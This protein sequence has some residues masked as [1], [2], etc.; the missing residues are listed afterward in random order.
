[1]DSLKDIDSLLLLL[2]P[3][4]AS[5]VLLLA[6]VAFIFRKPIR[7]HVYLIVLLLTIPLCAVLNK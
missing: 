6:C 3:P 4:L 7:R 1:M 5:A 2:A